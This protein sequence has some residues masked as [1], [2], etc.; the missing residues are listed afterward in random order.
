MLLKTLSK[1][2]NQQIG[3]YML[4]I[5]I[6]FSAGLLSG[7]IGFFLLFCCK[8]PNAERD[9]YLLNQ[10]HELKTKLEEEQEE[11]NRK[12]EIIFIHEETRRKAN[13]KIIKL[14]REIKR[15]ESDQHKQ[16]KSIG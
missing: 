5:F 7:I 8:E 12:E 2:F 14:N 16:T 11:N 4:A 3:A 1:S 6:Y 10:L 13:E 15:L 9:I